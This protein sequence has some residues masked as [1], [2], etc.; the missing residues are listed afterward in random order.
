MDLEVHPALP[1]PDCVALVREAEELGFDTIWFADSHMIWRDAFVIMGAV[2][3]AGGTINIGTG[4]SN[5]I[6]RHPTV[7]ASAL[8]T[9]EQLR[10]GRVLCGLGIG[11]S[12][13]YTLGL[14]PMK[15]RV[16]E[17]HVALMR[18]LW[19]KEPC[20]G[21]NGHAIALDWLEHPVDIP[22]YYGSSGPKMLRD[23]GRLCDGVVSYVGLTPERVRIAL[24]HI[25]AGASASGRRLSDIALVWW[26]PFN[27]SPDAT[28][29]RAGVKPHVARAILHAEPLGLP[30]DEQAVAA[31]L[32]GQY[33]W[34]EHMAAGSEHSRIVPDR[35]VERYAVAGTPPECVEQLRRLQACGIDH[36]GIIPMGSDRRAIIQLFAKSVLPRL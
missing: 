34:Y 15:R 25:E 13:V 1:S 11:D 29:A 6:T 32:K 30:D 35:M 7:V 19:R 21:E 23:G 26:V 31:E 28:Q 17:Q 36:V 22:V 8:A 20:R 16:L 27:V 18:A 24:G 4:V 3:A 5:T 12:S 14:K 33:D 2:A 9:L 10:P